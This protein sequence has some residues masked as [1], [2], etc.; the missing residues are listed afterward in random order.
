MKIILR[1]LIIALVLSMTACKQKKS[2][3]E[4]F[5]E[6]FQKNVEACTAEMISR[7][8]DSTSAVQKCACML[9]AAFEV[10]STMITMQGKELSD[11]LKANIAEIEAMCDSLSVQSDMLSW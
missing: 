6:S 10:D 1:L 5:N 7:G 3:T 4:L 9:R 2:C 8:A 11:F